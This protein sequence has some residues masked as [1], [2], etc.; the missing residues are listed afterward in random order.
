MFSM[1]D[2]KKKPK[3]LSINKWRLL[4]DKRYSTWCLRMRIEKEVQMSLYSLVYAYSYLYFPFLA[5][6]DVRIIYFYFLELQMKYNGKI[7]T[8]Y[9][10]EEI[11]T[12]DRQTSYLFSDLQTHAQ[13]GKQVFLQWFER[14]ICVP[15][16]VHE[17]TR[18]P[19]KD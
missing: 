7:W 11:R 19:S 12:V 5:D 17:K 14:Q 8:K 6:I 9:H 10:N 13:T 4:L 3:R 18:H 15:A 1:G 2:K 16:I